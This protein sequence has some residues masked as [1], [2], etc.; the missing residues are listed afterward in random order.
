MTAS[1]RR[2]SCG[3]RSG[4]IRHGRDRSTAHLA[5]D[6]GLRRDVR[7]RGSDARVARRAAAAVA[8]R[9]A[10][11]RGRVL[12]AV[13]GAAHRPR[14]RHHRRRRAA[15]QR[16]PAAVRLPAGP[17]LLAHRRRTVRQ[18]SRRARRA[19][20]AAH[21]DR[22]AAGN[23]RPVGRA[24]PDEER[25][26]AVFWLTALLWVGSRFVLLNAYNGLETGLALL[27][28]AAAWRCCQ[29]GWLEGSKLWG[30][31]L[32][33][34]LLVLA[35]IDAAVFV[36]T[37]GADRTRQAGA[38]VSNAAAARGGAD[39]GAVGRCRCPGGCTASSASVR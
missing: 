10:A 11:H 39:A 9:S 24:A 13:G 15:D 19:L 36:A 31:A 14:A 38:R 3:E 29:L 4:R 30:L 20:A 8:R 37:L 32:V 22:A 23:D 28:Y 27:L 21:G 18:P 12:H 35:R 33:L 34:G 2:E 6:D 16:D 25:R 26:R 7:L 17:C 5:F 1:P